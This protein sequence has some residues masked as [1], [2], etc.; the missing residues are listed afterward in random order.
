MTGMPSSSAGSLPSPNPTGMGAGGAVCD[1]LCDSVGG[2]I[3]DNLWVAE[4]DE[5][6]AA[7]PRMSSW[8]RQDA[9]WLVG[10]EI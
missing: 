5:L 4:L 2:G 1:R 10:G 8:W 9:G 7:G 3:Q 6:V